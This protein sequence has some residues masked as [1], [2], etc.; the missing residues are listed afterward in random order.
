M[1]DHDLLTAVKEDF[2]A[3]RMEVPAELILAGGRSRRRRRRCAQGLAVAAVLA[4]G[5]G[6]GVP[7]L[8]S[9]A[10]VPGPP[11]EHAI[12][13]RPSSGGHTGDATLAAWAVVRQP[14]GA[15]A[16]TIHDLRNIAGLQQRLN[17]ADVRAAVYAR[18][19]RLP[20]CLDW[21]DA[22]RLGA[23]VTSKAALGPNDVYFV[24]HPAAIPRGSTL[25][26]D[27]LPPG[28]PPP[29]SAPHQRLPARTPVL[30]GVGFNGGGPKA[31]DAPTIN[32]S[33]I[34]TNSNCS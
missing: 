34:Y 16:V 3:V 27:V 29:E 33:L 12:A 5:L 31:L 28:W 1:N 18:A 32:L 25:Q 23:I 6:L 19:R 21:P 20:G 13:Q 26:I 10:S 4:A 2:A 14:D 7:A 15:V 9:G 17:A 11:A 24:I 30:G 22:G 8:T